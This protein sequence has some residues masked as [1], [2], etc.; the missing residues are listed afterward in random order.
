MENRPLYSADIV[1]IIGSPPRWLLR[2]GSGLLLGAVLAILLVLMLVKVPEQSGSAVLL[3]STT[4]PYYLTQLAVGQRL[5]VTSGQQV[6]QGQLLMQPLT[7]QGLGT[8]APF[9][10]TLYYAG[11]GVAGQPGDTLAVLVPLHNTYRFRGR[12]ELGYLSELRRS[13][14]LQLQVPLD[15]QHRDLL[16]LTGSLSYVSPVLRGDQVAYTGLLDSASCASLSRHAAA[17]ASMPATLRTT[18]G[19]QPLLQRIFH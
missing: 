18:A 19:Q 13:R 8:P 11:S 17:V 4:P 9:S 3:S 5:L 16:L 12:A 15:G 14:S 2:A 7:Q 6:A 10:G 1:E